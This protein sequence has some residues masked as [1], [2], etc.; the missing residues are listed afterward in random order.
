[1]PLDYEAL[2]SYY[3]DVSSGSFRL[4]NY[5]GGTHFQYRGIPTH[6]LDFSLGALCLWERLPQ[7]ERDRLLSEGLKAMEAWKSRR[8]KGWSAVVL[9]L[10]H[11]N[12][13]DRALLLTHLR[14]WGF[15]GIHSFHPGYADVLSDA[16][17]SV[18]VLPSPD[19]AF[20]YLVELEVFLPEGNHTLIWGADARLRWKP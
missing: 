5:T 8:T 1:M 10:K 11:W 4:W 2:R 13:S 15:E 6:S 7:V 3:R 17:F 12:D 18:R 20:P 9:P 16:R 19:P 14:N